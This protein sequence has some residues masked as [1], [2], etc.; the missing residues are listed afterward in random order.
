[1]TG[2]NSIDGQT[3]NE[4]GSHTNVMAEDVYFGLAVTSHDNTQLM[5]GT[6]DHVEVPTPGPYCT[7]AY[8][9]NPPTDSFVGAEYSGDNVYMVLDFRPGPNAEWS[10]AYFSDE[11]A[12]V[13]NRDEAHSLG[14]VPPWPHVDE[15]AFVVGYN[16]PAIP[17][18]ARAP[19]VIGTT[20]YW[21]VDY[22]IGAYCLGRTWE[23]T[24]I[25]KCAWGPSPV[26]GEECVSA[27]PT[28]TWHL[29]GL[30]TR[31]YRKCADGDNRPCRP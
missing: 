13:D 31:G 4:V 12:D 2:Y 14:T 30:D 5:T 28:C 8:L 1:M 25:P 9:P 21:C 6:F 26:D 18:F 24:V 20:Y 10:K 7:A 11:K 27:E 29:G 15:N 17:E 19:L 16:D 22:W 23:F 3:W